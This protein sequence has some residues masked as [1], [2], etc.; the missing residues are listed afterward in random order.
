M[1]NMLRWLG[2][3]VMS[4]ANIAATLTPGLSVAFDRAQVNSKGSLF[5]AFD[6]NGAM[7]GW[8]GMVHMQKEAA[9]QKARAV[10][11][12]ERA[13]EQRRKETNVKIIHGANGWVV[14][15]EGQEPWV[16]KELDELGDTIS[17]AMAVKVLEGRK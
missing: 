7:D 10:A 6:V 17:K 2:M 9:Y 8:P 11:D 5:D 3:G 15:V 16:C 1:K 14:E 12:Y 13:M 4:K